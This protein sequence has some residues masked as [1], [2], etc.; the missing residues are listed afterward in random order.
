MLF[1]GLFQQG[2]RVVPVTHRGLLVEPED[3]REMEW[4]RPVGQGLFELPVNAIADAFVDT[5]A[6]GAAMP[7]GAL[8]RFGSDE[9]AP[10]WVLSPL[11]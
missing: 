3:L 2:S 6:R 8:I 9:D 10:R 7:S 11:G 1:S 5:L 4:I